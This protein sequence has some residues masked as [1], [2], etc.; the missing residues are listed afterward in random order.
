MLDARVKEE[1]KDGRALE[2]SR[3]KG[4]REGDPR[5]LLN[6]FDM[7]NSEKMQRT[8]IN[9]TEYVHVFSIKIRQCQHF[10]VFPVVLFI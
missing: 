8:A 3:E 10:A 1:Q 5:S 2:R 6:E 4:R 7:Q 9:V